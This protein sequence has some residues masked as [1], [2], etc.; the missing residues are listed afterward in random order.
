MTDTPES[1]VQERQITLNGQTLTLRYGWAAFTA[2]ADALG[3]TVSNIDSVLETMPVSALN[4]I[5]WAGLLDHHPAMSEADVVTLLNAGT[6]KAA[7]KE[8]G[9]AGALFRAS[10][11][12]VK[13]EDDDEA[14]DPPT[15]AQA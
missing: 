3:C 15:A 10:M 13:A 7:R 1:E 6:I 12:D 9:K 4:K 8:I 5:V 2:L 14:S 11:N